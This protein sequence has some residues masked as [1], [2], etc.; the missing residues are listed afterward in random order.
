[1]L[2]TGKSNLIILYFTWPYP[3]ISCS[4]SL[5]CIF[6]FVFVTNTLCCLVTQSCPALCHPMDCN[7]PGLPVLYCLP[8]LAQTHVNWVSD[9]NQSSYPLSSPSPPIFN[10]S[11]HQGL[12]KWEF[13]ASSCQSIGVSA[14]ASILPMNIQDWFPLGWSGLISLQ[15]KRLS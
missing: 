13:F 9:V 10:L 15:S 8:E 5:L 12:F 1:M 7:T 6:F 14:S 3:Q 11:Q 2:F 4:S